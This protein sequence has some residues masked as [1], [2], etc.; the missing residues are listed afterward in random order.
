M[1][2]EPLE[3]ELGDIVK[4]ARTGLGLTLRQFSDRTDI[5]VNLLEETEAY[6]YKPSDAELNIISRELVLSPPKLNDIA[7][8]K[9]YPEEYSP[10]PTSPNDELSNVIMIKGNIGSYKVNGYILIDKKNGV[11]VAFDTG[12]DCR[13]VLES[14]KDKGLKLIYIFLTHGHFDHTGGLME[15]C[16]ATGACIGLPEREPDIEID[17]DISKSVFFVRDGSIYKAGFLEVMAIA[18]PGHTQGSTC[19]VTESYCFS[20]DTLFAGSVGKAYSTAGYKTLLNS[21]RTKILSLNKTVR[22][23]PGHGPATTVGEEVMHN[24]FFLTEGFS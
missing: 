8:G 9:W 3:D 10:S 12:N 14:L 13:K 6:T 22:I 7:K 18:T 23:F 16:R 2:K 15:I 20:G 5:A 21:V 19:Y 4:K 17:K 24:P 11:A 1:N